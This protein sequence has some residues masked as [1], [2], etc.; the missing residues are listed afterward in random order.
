[1]TQFK[2]KTYSE[3]DRDIFL[4]FIGKLSGFIVKSKDL[5]WAAPKKNIHVYLDEFHDILGDYQDEL[6]EG[7]MGILGQMGPDDVP[8]QGC[9]ES[10]ADS[11]IEAV[12]NA[13]KD[14]YVQIPEGSEFKGITGET[15]SFIQ[16]INKYKYLFSLCHDM[17]E[18]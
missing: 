2:Q 11:F 18:R 16:N 6:A 15:E 8:F 17:P 5:H 13:T 4:N 10:N 12:L 7:Y 9:G 14:F 1:M 3:G